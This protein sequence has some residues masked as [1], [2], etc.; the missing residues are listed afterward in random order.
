LLTLAGNP[1]GRPM[2]DELFAANPGWRELIPRLVT[3][4]VIP[5]LPG[6]AELLTGE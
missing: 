6:V 4:G 5:N 2:L 3:A 1:G